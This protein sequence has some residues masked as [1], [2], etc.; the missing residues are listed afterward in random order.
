[1]IPIVL[2]GSGEAGI[3]TFR[4]ISNLVFA[5][6]FLT[7]VLASCKLKETLEKPEVGTLTQYV[8]MESYHHITGPD[9]I[10][11]RCRCRL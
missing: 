7:A 10:N 11:I 6:E 4:V 1:M 5:K 8:Y 9:D 2:F 3:L